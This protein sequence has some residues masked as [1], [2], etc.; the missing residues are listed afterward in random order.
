MATVVSQHVRHLGRHL[1]FLKKNIFRKTAT[2]FTGISGKHVFLASNRK[3]IENS[4][5]KKNLEEIFPKFN[6]FVFRTLICIN[7]YA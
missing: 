6:S 4:L 2:N 5:K 1:G 3:I 7:N